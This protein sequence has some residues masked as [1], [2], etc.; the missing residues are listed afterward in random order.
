MIVEK[1]YNFDEIL[2]E[3]MKFPMTLPEYHKKIIT[4]I[5]RETHQ[6]LLKGIIDPVIVTGIEGYCMISESKSF[7]YTNGSV[8]VGLL[9]GKV[10]YYDLRLEP[11]ELLRH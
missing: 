9:M 10:V 11:N 2:I 4:N 8:S 3:D 6:F 5:I 7:S 1:I